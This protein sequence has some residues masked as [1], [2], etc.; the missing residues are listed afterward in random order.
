MN[1]ITHESEFGRWTVKT[2]PPPADLAHIVETYWETTGSVSYG[3]EKIVPSGN[4]ELMVNLGPPQKILSESDV[5]HEAAVNQAWICG[6]QTQPLFAAPANGPSAFYTHFVGA[7]LYPLG[8]KQLLGIDG[9]DFV[10]TVT[11]L[12]EILPRDANQIFDTIAKAD[13]TQKRF[14]AM[15]KSL[16][17][18]QSLRFTDVSNYVYYAISKTIEARGNVRVSSIQSELGIS[19]KHLN[20]VFQSSLGISPKTFARLT[21]FRWILDNAFVPT[22]SWARVA[23]D[24]G[25]FD[26]SHLIHDFRQFAGETPQSFLGNRAPD[27]ESVNYSGDFVEKVLIDCD[28]TRQR[29]R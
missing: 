17:R 2:S 12:R 29:K 24:L 1:E 16:R 8:I 3:F 15:S 21:R 4:A 6:I 14:L 11:E 25:Y 9:G 28:L 7:S 22:N 13:S 5:G 19:R 26:Q 18:V 10:N 27:G 20:H 23:A